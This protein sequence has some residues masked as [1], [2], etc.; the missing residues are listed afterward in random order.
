MDM[1]KEKAL[2]IFAELEKDKEE[3]VLINGALSKTI[4]G[5]LEYKLLKT[6]GQSVSAISSKMGLKPYTQKKYARYCDKMSEKFLQRM[7]SRCSE[8]DISYK[9]GIINGYTGLVLLICE[10]MER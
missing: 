5:V 1:Q 8:F 7:L 2:M 9:T 4:M 3:P 10:M 6:E